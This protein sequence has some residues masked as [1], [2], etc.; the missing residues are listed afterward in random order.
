M[1]KSK[2]KFQSIPL[3]V[4]KGWFKQS[5]KFKTKLRLIELAYIEL[6]HIEYESFLK[7]VEKN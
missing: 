7:F 3:N 2:Y 4:I 1:R 6:N 5:R